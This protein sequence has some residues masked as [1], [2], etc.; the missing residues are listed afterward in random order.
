MP[1][2]EEKE[3]KEQEWTLENSGI[4]N[5][6]R[7]KDIW[8]ELPEENVPIIKLKVTVPLGEFKMM[9]L[10]DE[11][12]MMVFH[13]DSVGVYKYESNEAFQTMTNKLSKHD[14]QSGTGTFLLRKSNSEASRTVAGPNAWHMHYLVKVY[15]GGMS[16]PLPKNW[17]L[18]LL[19]RVKKDTAGAQL[20]LIRKKFHNIGGLSEFMSAVSSLNGILGLLQAV[21]NEEE[22]EE[23]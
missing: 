7:E 8:F 9:L 1:I 14:F 5:Y 4:L 15:L 20:Y 16:K 2:L 19:K 21:V 6:L 18:E 13:T 10:L 23:S 17:F 22:D 12:G 11:K 3:S